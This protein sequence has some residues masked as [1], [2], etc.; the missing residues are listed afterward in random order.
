V[1]AWWG[2]GDLGRVGGLVRMVREGPPMRRACAM[3]GGWGLEIEGSDLKGGGFYVTRGRLV[4][5]GG[6]VEEWPAA[7][8][9]HACKM[10]KHR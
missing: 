7:L 4:R 5:S 1:S 2:L 6:G 10:D 8:A 3:L 9:L